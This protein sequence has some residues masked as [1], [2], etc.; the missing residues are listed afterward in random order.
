MLS[1]F[2]DHMF[3][4]QATIDL[5]ARYYVQ[6]GIPPKDTTTRE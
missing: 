3:L 6:R 2:E 5:A 4:G 1:E